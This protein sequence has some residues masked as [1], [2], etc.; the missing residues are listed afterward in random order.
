MNAVF[1]S[2]FE[3]EMFQVNGVVMLF[4]MTGVNLKVISTFN[5]PESVRY[6]KES[7]VIKYQN[8]RFSLCLFIRFML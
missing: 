2:M 3:D 1:I 5:D 7:Q 8:K 6:H 4:D